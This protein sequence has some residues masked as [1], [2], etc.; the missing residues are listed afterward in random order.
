MGPFVKLQQ[1][2][3]PGDILFIEFGYAPQF[4]PPRFQIVALEEYANR[5]P[6]DARHQFLLDRLLRYTANRPAGLAFRRRNANRRNDEL[7][8][9]VIEQFGGARPLTIIE[10]QGEATGVVAMGNFSNGLGCKFK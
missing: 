7:F 1:V 2:F 4:F 9:K 6:V 10:S 5:F 8:F 3:H